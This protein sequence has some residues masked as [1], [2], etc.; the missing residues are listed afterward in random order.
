MRIAKAQDLIQF[1]S[2]PST[3][4]C[5][6]AWVIRSGTRRTGFVL[7]L[8]FDYCYS[9]WKFL[10]QKRKVGACVGSAV[11]L[12]E[13]FWAKR[14]YYIQP[15]NSKC[16]PK[17][18]QDWFLRCLTTAVCSLAYRQSRSI[19]NKAAPGNWTVSLVNKKSMADNVT[20]RNTCLSCSYQV[21][22]SE[23]HKKGC[24]G[25]LSSFPHAGDSLCPLRG[26]V[27]PAPFVSQNFWKDCSLWRRI[28]FLAWYRATPP[29]SPSLSL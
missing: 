7:F 10:H 26:N 13:R 12:Y 23:V 11:C 17:F 28:F 15:L 29:S 4:C 18:Q 8:L 9:P 5:N 21:L 24:S 25:S 22:L 16:T 1:N 3:S 20:N 6:T 19:T 2:L 27:H 14:G